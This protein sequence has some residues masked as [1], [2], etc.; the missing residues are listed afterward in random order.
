MQKIINDLF[1]IN[2]TLVGSGYDKALEYIR[3][4]LPRMEIME[5]KT[6]EEYGTWKIPQKWEVKDAW[7]KHKGK[8]IIDFKKE[9]LSLVVGAKPIHG[10]VDLKEL[11]NHIHFHS[12]EEKAIPYVFKYYDK[13]WG[14]CLALEQYNK[15]EEGEYEVFIDTKETEGTLKIGQYIIRGD[16]REIFIMVHLDHPYQA[17]DNLSGVVSAI[18]LAKSLECKHTVKV[19]FVPETIGSIVYAHTQD[20]SKIDYGITLDMVG[21]DNSIIMQQTFFEGE[22]INRAGIMAMSNISP[23]CYR[24]APFRAPLG[25]DEYIFNDPLIGIPTLLFSRYPYKEYHTNLDTPAIIKEDKIKETIEIVKKTIEIMDKDWIPERHFKGPL[26]RSRY[27]VQHLSKEQNRK[28][29]FFFYLM[30]GKRSVLDLSYICQLEFDEMNELLTKLKK[31][32]IIKSIQRNIS[33]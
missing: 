27:G 10:V 12:E 14:F 5:F 4:I 22:R 6:G 23:E 1:K 32:D 30:D 33:K 24:K 28:Y 8:K 16:D 21:N 11:Q 25:A 31:D 26:M 17:N 7:V 20:L 3:G 19:I 29:D 18:N 15:L 9:P 2:R 13:D